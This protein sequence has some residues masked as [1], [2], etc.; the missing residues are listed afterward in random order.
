MISN[1]FL[2]LGIASILQLAFPFLTQAIVDVGINN[3]NIDFIYL[4]LIAQLVLFVSQSFIQIIRS[5]LLLHIT[6]RV[7]INLISDFLF[8]LMKLPIAFF[9]SK[10]TGDLLQRIQDHNRIRDFLSTVT[11]NVLF[12]TINVIIFGFVLAYYYLP[13][14]YIFLFGASLFVV[15]TLLFMK[16]RAELDYKRFD[17]ASG[18][19]SSLVQLINGM[20]EIKLNNS[21]RRRRWEW[22]AIQIR[23][24]KISEKSLSVALWQGSGA[25]FLDQLKNILISFVAAKAVIDGQ[26]TLG[27]MLSVQFIIGQ[28][29]LPL[30]N[31][32]G[33][34]SISPGC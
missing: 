7:N 18:N 24:Y 21:E 9:D 14:F 19:Q 15:W 20:Q 29:N 32:I 28:L 17:E 5:W 22:E 16:K 34:Y 31:F 2:G 8:K 10:N 1:L 25:N 11:L 30:N 33:F 27:M 13:I 6:N 12:S 26:I 4:I 3:Q 23:L